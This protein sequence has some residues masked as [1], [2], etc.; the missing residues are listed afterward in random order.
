MIR[1]VFLSLLLAGAL[2]SPP[3]HAQGI[4]Q[5]EKCLDAAF[6]GFELAIDYC[7]RAIKSGDLTNRGLGTAYYNRGRLYSFQGRYDLALPDINETVRLDALAPEPDDLR[8]A[9]FNLRGT[10]QVALRNFDGALADFDESIRLYPRNAA[11]YLGRGNAWLVKRDA[12]RAIADFDRALKADVS[13]KTS[14]EAGAGSAYARRPRNFD[15]TNNDS[16]ARLGRGRAYLIKDDRSAALVEFG[17]AIRI[18]PASVQAL[19]SRAALREQ[20]GDYESAIGDYTAALRVDP[21]DAPSYFQRGL[22][23]A[24]KGE[25]AH[26]ALD[27]DET[28]RRAPRHHAA[29][30]LRAVIALGEGHYEQAADQFGDVMKTSPPQAALMLWRHV[31]RAR[32]APDAALREDARDELRRDSLKLTDRSIHAQIVGFYLGRSDDSALRKPGRSTSDACAADYFLAQHA[33]IAGDKA[34]GAELLSAVVKECPATAQETWAAR[35]E[36]QRREK[37]AAR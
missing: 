14:V 4:W 8:A 27:F 26:G 36:L 29:R 31:A 32:S 13:D 11:P 35:L 34:R 15:R 7:T 33:F 23:W 17:E 2:A 1:G 10:I 19:K 9:T 12:D 22:A 3:A 21:R 30:F 5:L 24:A 18:N 25:Y 16:A 37:G 20:M 6:M 28:L